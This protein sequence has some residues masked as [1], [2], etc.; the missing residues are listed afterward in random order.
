M[1]TYIEIILRGIGSFYTD[2]ILITAQY[3]LKYNLLNPVYNIVDSK[4]SN[5]FIVHVA[6]KYNATKSPRALSIMMKPN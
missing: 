4:E 6:R 3:T 1:P 2:S 5:I